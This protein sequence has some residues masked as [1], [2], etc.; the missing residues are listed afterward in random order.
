[1]ITIRNGTATTT[2]NYQRLDY[3]PG[4]LRK[5]QLAG[6]ILRTL[7]SER[8]NPTTIRSNRVIL[9]LTAAIGSFVS[10]AVAAFVTDEI[11]T[12]AGVFSFATVFTAVLAAVAGILSLITEAEPGP[13]D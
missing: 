7:V 5:G 6:P 2:A 4:A 3:P 13:S 8:I 9:G 12:V 10:W 11:L 1:M